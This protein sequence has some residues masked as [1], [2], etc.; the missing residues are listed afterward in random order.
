MFIEQGIQ[1][2]NTSLPAKYLFVLD[3]SIFEVIIIITSN[4]YT[5]IIASKIGL[6]FLAESTK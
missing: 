5:F 2:D 6:F 1:Y 3:L 4:S